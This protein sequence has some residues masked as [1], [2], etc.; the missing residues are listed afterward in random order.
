MEN[1]KMKMQD[2]EYYVISVSRDDIILGVLGASSARG[3]C[4]RCFACA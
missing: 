1:R 2:T 3:I 4:L